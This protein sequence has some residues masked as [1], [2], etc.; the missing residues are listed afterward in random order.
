MKSKGLL[1]SIVSASAV[2][3]GLSVGAS[4]NNGMLKTQFPFNTQ[5]RVF[6]TTDVSAGGK[7]QYYGG[8]VIANAKVYVVYWGSKVT[9]DTQSKIGGFFHSILQ[10]SYFDW[11]S[12]YNTSVKAVDGR[13]GT[14]QSIGRG[15][16]AGQITIQPS[17]ELSDLTTITDDQIQAELQK[18]IDKGVLPKPDENTLY[19]TY[20]PPGVT[21]T[22]FGAASCQ[23]FC[24]Y[25][26]FKGAPDTAHFY[27]GV[28][29]DIG[30]A[31]S[32]GCGFAA[33]S[34]DSL[35]A[36]SSHELMEA[37][38][39][40]FPTPGDKPGYPQAWN[41]TDGQEIGDLCA[42]G[43]NS[44]SSPNGNYTVQSEWDNSI[45]A[46]TSKDWVSAQ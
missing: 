16:Y 29:P 28:M 27:Y 4:A 43:N 41:S 25:H 7:L 11:L 17:A 8:P 15:N 42:G 10:S 40:P 20:F 19:M 37:V 33:T 5:S 45:N 32:W 39:D 38:T 46:C 3:L 13:Q 6:T 30:G 35:S 26:G 34:F 9:Q 1:L 14:N 12:E 44:V 36:I 18:Q 24:A 23:D 31:C 21:I 2:T 22:A